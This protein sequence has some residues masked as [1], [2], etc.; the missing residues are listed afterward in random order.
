MGLYEC[1]GVCLQKDYKTSNYDYNFGN[2]DS[3]IE[4]K[5]WS[6]NFVL[7]S[8]AKKALNQALE[9]ITLVK[10]RIDN[11]NDEE[12]KLSN[13]KK[14][15]NLMELIERIDKNLPEDEWY[16]Y[17]LKISSY[18]GINIDKVDYLSIKFL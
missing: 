5:E 3:I 2:I 7:Y 9:Y 8:E 6:Q 18:D 16:F 13:Q 1:N 11:G 10:E 15:N 4:P 14:Y 12:A 17:E